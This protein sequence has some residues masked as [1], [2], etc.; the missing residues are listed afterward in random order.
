[1][2]G[3]LAVVY[4]EEQKLQKSGNLSK[5]GYRSQRGK[6]NDSKQNK[7]HIDKKNNVHGSKEEKNM[8]PDEFE[9]KQ[10]VY[11]A[12]KAKAE[13]YDQLAQGA[14]KE[15]KNAFLVNF[16]KKPLGNSEDESDNR[17]LSVPQSN[18]HNDSHDVKRVKV[19]DESNYTYECKCI[20][21][22]LC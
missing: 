1:M 10:M 19:S 13:L 21:I 3:L 11:S 18:S 15:G 14:V 9:K 5:H 16:E 17:A 8:D 6:V 22:L 4:D 20:Q 7:K 2:I 12:L